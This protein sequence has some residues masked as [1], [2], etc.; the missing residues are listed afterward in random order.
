MPCELRWRRSSNLNTRVFTSGFSYIEF[1]IGAFQEGQFIRTRIFATYGNPLGGFFSTFYNRRGPYYCPPRTIRYELPLTDTQK[2]LGLNFDSITGTLSG[3]ILDVDAFT[4]DPLSSTPIDTKTYFD[5][6][7]RPNPRRL[8]FYGKAYLLE[9]PNEFIEREFYMDVATSW[10]S[11]R[12]ALMIGSRKIQT[13]FFIEGKKATN[14]Q[15]FS[16]LQSRGF[17]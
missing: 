4:G 9:N 13:D 17:I 10:D 14:E 1:P 7:R 6:A 5:F 15:Y 16:Y 3:R 11:R 12:R 2:S 8:R